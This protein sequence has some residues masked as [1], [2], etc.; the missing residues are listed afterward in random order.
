MRRP[1]ILLRLNSVPLPMDEWHGRLGEAIREFRLQRRLSQEA[2]GFRAGLHRNYVG[3]LERGEHTPTFSTLL[4]VAHGLGVPV[5]ALMYWAEEQSPLLPP[6]KTARVTP[7]RR[8]WC[9]RERPAG[10]K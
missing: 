6:T 2:L 4:K 8:G 3:S 10:R 7:R 9:E 1:L 5:S